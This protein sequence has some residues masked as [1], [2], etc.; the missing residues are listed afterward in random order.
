MDWAILEGAF[1][2]IVAGATKLGSAVGEAID[3]AVSGAAAALDAINGSQG[4]ER[5]FDQLSDL[6]ERGYSADF[7]QGQAL[8]EALSAGE[9]SLESYRKTLAAVAQEGGAFATTA[10]EMIAASKQL[11][12]FK[13]PEPQGQ[14][15]RQR[16]R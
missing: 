7:V 11:D 5:I 6:A 13:M 9:I 8:S 14:L 12:G 1:D 15:S 4:V 10:K 2:A 3:V 16:G